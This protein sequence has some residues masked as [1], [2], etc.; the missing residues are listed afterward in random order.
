MELCQFI[1]G[2]DRGGFE[3]EEVSTKVLGSESEVHGCI[4]LWAIRLVAV[5]LGRGEE[6]DVD[7]LRFQRFSILI[8]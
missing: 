4:P 5:E 2:R 1:A 7:H 8:Y 3:V 6:N